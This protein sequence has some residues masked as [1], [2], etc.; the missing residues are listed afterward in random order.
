MPSI[1]EIIG[2]SKVS[3][4]LSSMA[5]LKGGLYGKGL[6]LQ[7]TRKLY[8]IR[9]NVEYRYVQ[10]DIAGGETPSAALVS[11]SN[12]LYSLCYA[13]N[14]ATNIF[15][16]GSGGGS[17]TPVSPNQPTFPLYIFGGATGSSFE[18]DGKTYLNPYLFGLQIAIF[19]DQYSQQ[20]LLAGD[21]TFTV[22]SSGLVMN[23]PGFDANTQTW[24]IRVEQWF[25]NIPTPPVTT[26]ELLINSTD[27]LLINSTDSLLIN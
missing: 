3:Q 11:V 27:S 17:V 21:E 19:P 22:N 4:Y 23:I 15:N 7:L 5:I 14:E 24:V 18:S 26:N 9:K 6:D 13:V 2:I 1:A 8:S 20:F 10:E 16:N 25:G 12:K